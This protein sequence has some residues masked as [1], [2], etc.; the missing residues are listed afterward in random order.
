MTATFWFGS[1][2][3]SIVL[4][5]LFAVR[6]ELKRIPQ[7]VFLNVLCPFAGLFYALYVVHVALPELV[8]KQTGHEIESPLQPYIDHYWALVKEKFSQVFAPKDDTDKTL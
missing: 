1:I 8:K 6:F 7:L 4:T 5:V 2:I 3:V